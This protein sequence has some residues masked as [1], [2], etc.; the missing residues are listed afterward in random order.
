VINKRLSLVNQTTKQTAA[1]KPFDKLETKD[2]KGVEWE[3]M[4]EANSGKIY[5]T[6]NVVGSVDEC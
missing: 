2:S 3:L 5:E 6:E 4:C 1:G